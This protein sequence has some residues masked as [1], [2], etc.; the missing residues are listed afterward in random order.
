[1]KWAYLPI[2][3]AL[4]FFYTKFSFNDVK[5]PGTKEN[6]FSS[7]RAPAT[8]EEKVVSIPAI[9][10][11]PASILYKNLED[12][13]IFAP[14][15]K[16]INFKGTIIGNP[17]VESFGY[18]VDDKGRPF[19]SLREFPD[20]T[21]G[22]FVHDVLVHLVSAKTADKKIT[23]I[24]YFD[25]YKSGLQDQPHVYSY[26]VE[27]G[28]DEAEAE[29][30]KAFEENVSSDFP[31]E[32]TKLKSTN[33]H[34]DIT[35]R[36]VIQS[37]L[38][39]K[40]PKIQF[41]DLYAGNIDKK[42]YQILVRMRPQDKIQWLEINESSTCDYDQTFNQ[43]TKSI[44]FEKR[45]ELIRNVVFD[46]RLNK[47]LDSVLIDKKYFSMKFSDQFSARLLL[48]QI[49]SDDYQDVIYDEAYTLGK[50]HRR[51]LR[52]KTDEYIKALATIPG[53]VVDEKMIEL[54]YKLKDLQ[55]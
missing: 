28:L 29:T 37:G 32:F 30:Q 15:Q 52:E 31:F 17:H 43:E 5:K 6:F 12:S 55:E 27:K 40:F 4:A 24:N 2:M 41:F 1:M 46:G 53:A 20:A 14:F 18:I 50:I 51:S 26:Y 21:E 54:K 9:K 42:S 35:G 49:P 45:F 33:H 13:S 39:K 38:K 8:V 7:V 36:N 3:F 16:V 25:A 10:R 44:P 23:W 34:P 19:F 11:V 22:S 47:S 48:G